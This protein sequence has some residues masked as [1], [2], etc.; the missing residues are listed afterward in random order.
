MYSKFNTKV[1]YIRND[2]NII[3]I[4]A[5]AA[6]IR[7]IPNIF[8][9]TYLISFLISSLLTFSLFL[10]LPCLPKYSINPNTGIAIV[11][12]CKNKFICLF[13]CIIPLS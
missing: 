10:F 2:T 7:D 8:C 5:I 11:I 13:A 3:P 6:N 12:S 1:L 4:N 9:I